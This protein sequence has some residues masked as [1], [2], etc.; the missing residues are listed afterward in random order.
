MR[1]LNY[2]QGSWISKWKIEFYK[3]HN[4]YKSKSDKRFIFLCVSDLKFDKSWR[5][6]STKLQYGCGWCVHSGN[7]YPC[8]HV[9]IRQP[10]FKKNIFYF[11][12]SQTRSSF[13]MDEEFYAVRISL[14]KFWKGCSRSALSFV[15]IYQF[16][17]LGIFRFLFTKLENGKRS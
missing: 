4:H 13:W 9:W 6:I 5:Y 2:L 15:W 14:L 12:N 16:I 10:L 8:G 17:L 3:N 7:F 11:T 1:K